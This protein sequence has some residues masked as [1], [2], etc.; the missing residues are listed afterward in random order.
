MGSRKVVHEVYLAGILVGGERSLHVELQRG[1]Q[2]GIRLTSGVFATNHERM[3]FG[4]SRRVDHAHHRAFVVGGG[5]KYMQM[6]E[7]NCWMRFPDG[8][9]FRPVITGWFSEFATLADERESGRTAY[10]QG[11]AR[12]AGSTYDPTSHYRAAAVLEFFA[13]QGLTQDGLRER[14]QHQVGLLM[15]AFDG[16]DLDPAV[17]DRDRSVPLGAVAG[18]LALRTP[19]A[20]E[21]CKALASRGVMTDYRGEVLRLGPAPYLTDD[22]L[23]TAVEALGD[24]VR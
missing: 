3:R 24:V 17:V 13:S 5:Y 11:A 4:Q 9:S 8:C 20:G 15:E 12:F 18:F 6:G 10:G 23:R 21:L 1:G 14:S 16:L 19:R 2:V 22:Q 7:G